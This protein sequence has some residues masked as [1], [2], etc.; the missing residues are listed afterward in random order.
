MEPRLLSVSAG[1]SLCRVLLCCV[2]IVSAV[3]VIKEVCVR[4]NQSEATRPRAQA[5]E[6]EI[7][8]VLCLCVCLCVFVCV[9][10]HSQGLRM[11][12]GYTIP[13]LGT[14]GTTSCLFSVAP[15][16]QTHTL[17]HI[18]TYSPSGVVHCLETCLCSSY[19]ESWR[20]CSLSCPCP[21]TLATH[22]LIDRSCFL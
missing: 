21:P 6:E 14:N 2:D 17:T 15:Q 10:A 12:Q 20:C 19:C 7:G 22:F 13:L 9:R 1:L 8:L 3:G 11:V 16:Q 4:T 18:Q 5:E